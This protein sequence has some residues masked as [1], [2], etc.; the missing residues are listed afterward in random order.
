MTELKVVKCAREAIEEA[1]NI[2]SVGGLVVYPTDTVYGLGCDPFNA[3][4]VEKVF[5]LKKR[6]NR[7]LPILVSDLD[8]AEQLVELG[9]VGKELAYRFWPGA[10]TIVAPL[11]KNLPLPDVLTCGF[12]TLGVRLPNHACILSLLKRVGG[13]L[14]GTSA[15][16]SGDAPP[17][18]LEDAVRSLGG[19]ADIYL[20][21]GR[22]TL[23]RESTVV[24]ICGEGVRVVREGALGREVV[25]EALRALGFL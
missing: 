8:L 1:A 7:P 4:A 24:D 25:F 6:P 2:I 15:N 11:K 3:E 20:D 21:G 12:K 13:F 10:L 9:R 19:G 14:V 22:A 5:K 16:R 17:L 23:G 18:T